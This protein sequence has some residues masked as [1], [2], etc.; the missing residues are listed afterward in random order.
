MVTVVTH[1][2][3]RPRLRLRLGLWSLWWRFRLDG[4]GSALGLS[5]EVP[6]RESRLFFKSLGL[7]VQTGFTG[8]FL[9]G[10]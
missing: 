8:G 7:G 10:S 4:L 5:L 9:G 3:L 6:G 2:G 1:K